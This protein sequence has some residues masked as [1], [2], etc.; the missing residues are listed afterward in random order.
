MKLL[1]KKNLKEENYDFFH[2]THEKIENSF[3][4]NTSTT[5]FQILIWFIIAVVFMV[6][7]NKFYIN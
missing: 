7:W 4:P 3:K 5:I 1:H 2:G 6:L